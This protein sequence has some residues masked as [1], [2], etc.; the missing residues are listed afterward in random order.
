MSPEIERALAALSDQPDATQKIAVIS[1]VVDI[2]ARN[3]AG[4][5]TNDYN[6]GT[7]TFD[8][9]FGSLRFPR[10]YQR[11]NETRCPDDPMINRR[12]DIPLTEFMAYLNDWY[13]P[14]SRE[15]RSGVP[16]VNDPGIH[17]S[18]AREVSA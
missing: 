8:W 3:M 2:M 16:M 1:S 18:A 9:V 15:I 6:V 10:L 17:L 11:G 5:V 13:W 14:K 7:D 4:M 12:E